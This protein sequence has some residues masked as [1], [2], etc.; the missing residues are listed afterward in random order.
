MASTAETAIRRA[1]SVIGSAYTYSGYVWTGD[2]STSKF[3]CSGLVDYAF[4]FDSNTH[5]PESYSSITGMKKTKGQLSPGDLV[6]YEY[7][8]RKPGHVGIYLGN[9]QIIDSEPNG[10]VSIRDVGYP[11]TYLGGGSF[12][13][14]SAV[15]S[16]STSNSSSSTSSASSTTS[17]SSGTKC[18]PATDVKYIKSSFED[19]FNWNIKNN[20]MENG[21]I[22]CR[23]NSNYHVGQRLIL[24]SDNTEY[25]IE[26]VSQSF[27]CYGNWTTTLGVTRGIEPQ[28]RFTPPWGMA[29]EMTPADMNALTMLTGNYKVDWTNLPQVNVTIGTRGNSISGASSSSGS[30]S[31]SSVSNLSGGSN[32]EQI[33]NSTKSSLGINSAAACGI[34]A[35]IECES[36]FSTASVGDGGTSIGIC[37]W[38]NSRATAL[39]SYCSSHGLPSTSLEGQLGYLY[40]ELS[41]SY[42]GVLSTLR[43]VPNSAQGAYNA[44]YAWCVS[45]EVPANKYVKAQERG[46]IAK[47]KYWPTYGGR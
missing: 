3:T 27:N 6:Y 23:G 8:S 37:Q 5:S 36:G 7:R 30:S 9:N 17:S 32:A 42:S 25:Y 1:K 46:N 14:S 20:V 34:L 10:G 12:T 28:N 24:E 16:G 47:N 41:Q 31:S 40:Q 33:F 38:H 43:S 18:Y 45:F 15:S 29:E 35:N 44:A 21:T 26:S 13:T 4:G 22:V 11:G 2:T 19:L 39:K